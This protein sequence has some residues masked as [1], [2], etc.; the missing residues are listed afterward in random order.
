MPTILLL[1]SL[2]SANDESRTHV[3][4]G[5]FGG[6]GAGAGSGAS[7]VGGFMAGV[8]VWIGP[9]DKNGIALDFQA[10]EGLASDDLRTMGGLYASARWPGRPGPFLSLGFAH[11]HETSWELAKTDMVGNTIATLPGINHRSGFEVG[12]GWDPQGPWPTDGMW[13]HLHPHF[14]LS[15]VALPG[16]DGPPVYV[17]L[18]IGGAFGLGK[19]TKAEAI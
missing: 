1:S 18:E 14:Q 13:G 4:A 6:A 17:M 7:A 8:N 9:Q 2:A 19:V 10:R 3:E 5:A 11:H 12:A 15:A 16:T